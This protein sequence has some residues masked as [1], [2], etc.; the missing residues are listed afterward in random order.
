MKKT[1]NAVY[2]EG[3]LYDHKLEKRVA[4][5]QAKNPGQEFI[6]GKI[7]V[8]TDDKMTNIVSVYYTYVSPF[9]KAGKENT[10][11]ST[12]ANII[13]GVYPTVVNGNAQTAAKVR[14]DTSINVNDF[15]VERNGEDT[16]VASKRNEDGFIHVIND[17]NRNEALR[18]TFDVDIVITSVAHKDADEDR[19]LPAKAVV[20]GFVIS[21]RGGKLVPADFSVLDQPGMDY[22]ESLELSPKKPVFTKIKGSQISTTITNKIEEQGAWN[23][24]VREVTSSRKDYAITWVA[25][26]PYEWDTEDTMLQSE[27]T[28][29]ISEREMHLAEVKQ[30]YM[31]RKTSNKVAP[32]KPAV[33]QTTAVDPFNF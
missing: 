18:N 12:L 4:G 3:Y 21:N 10:S 15:Y 9:T 31:S 2:L 33:A 6:R 26:D 14:I 25:Q 19:Q 32:A 1:K 20:K 28:N 5:A 16:L 27:L 23:T 7:D 30:S 11:F 17:L 24:I 29:L 22:F 8:A 13:S